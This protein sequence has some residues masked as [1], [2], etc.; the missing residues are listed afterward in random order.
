VII[1]FG[2][3]KERGGVLCRYLDVEWGGELYAIPLDRLPPER[4]RRL[5]AENAEWERQQKAWLDSGYFRIKT[6]TLSNRN[7]SLEDQG[8]LFDLE[9]RERFVDGHWT[10]AMGPESNI[11]RITASTN[12][13]VIWER[14]VREFDKPRKQ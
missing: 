2:H 10:R 6:F 14:I 11:L 13:M 5:A 9:Q 4:A 8:L 7:D 12:D 3:E 1:D